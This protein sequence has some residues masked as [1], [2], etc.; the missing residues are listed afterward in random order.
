MGVCLNRVTGCGGQRPKVEAC[1]K[2]SMQRSTALCWSEEEEPWDG[3]DL[4]GVF[5]RSLPSH[6]F[7]SSFQHGAVSPFHTSLTTRLHLGPLPSTA[8]SFTQTHCLPVP[9]PSK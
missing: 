7:S 5:P 1:N 3:S 8:C 6:G 4:T 9:P 2:T